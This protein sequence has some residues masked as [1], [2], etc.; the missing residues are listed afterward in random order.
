MVRV[1]R[2]GFHARDRPYISRYLDATRCHLYR[3]YSHSCWRKPYCDHCPCHRWRA[4]RQQRGGTNTS[5]YWP[6]APADASDICSRRHA[7]HT[8]QRRCFIR[9][10][11]HKCARTKIRNYHPTRLCCQ[12]SERISDKRVSS[13]AEFFSPSCLFPRGMSSIASSRY[14]IRD[15]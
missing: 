9:A 10:T 3:R 1:T 13:S 4:S 7:I 6:S 5:A 12:E 8:C 11:C 2:S 15:G 14:A